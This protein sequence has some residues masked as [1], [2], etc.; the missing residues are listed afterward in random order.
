MQKLVLVFILM[1][2]SASMA[3]EF[4]RS[5]SLEWEPIEGAATYDVEFAPTPKGKPITVLARKSFWNGKLPVGNYNMRVRAKD[6]RKVPGDWSETQ[7]M[8]VG[9][10]NAKLIYPSS[11]YKLASKEA[12]T[13][14]V[15]FKWQPVPG[16]EDYKIEVTSRDGKTKIVEETS[17][18][19]IK[20]KLPVAQEYTWKVLAQRDEVHSD[21][22]TVDE[23]F[24]Q[25]KK[26]DKPEIV[27]P[28]NRFV[29]TIEW[30]H[31]DFA[32]NF[33]YSIQ[34]LNPLTKKWENVGNKSEFKDTSVVFDPAWPGGQ[35]RISVRATSNVRVNS[36]ISQL[37]FPVANGDRSPAAEE[38]G[39]L[40]ES[41]NRT[42][43]WFFT[44][45][46]LV[47]G[48]SYKG[49]DYDSPSPNV[50][51]KDLF[52]GTGRFGVGF[53]DGEKPWGFLGIV[54]YSGFN[55][56]DRTYNFGSIEL[57]AIHRKQVSKDGELR[58]YVG[59]YYKE[60]PALVNLN[61]STQSFDV[62]EIASG[63]PHYG[64]EYWWALSQK[65]GFQV[66]GHVYY[67]VLTFKTPNGER[68]H[69]EMTYQLGLLGS[70]KLGSKTTG[71]MGY[72]YRLD[73]LSYDSKNN[74]NLN[75]ASF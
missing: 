5:V 45:S 35:Y 37:T 39:A 30:K 10:E 58:Q 23:F 31:P 63:G 44:A 15:V 52:G 75:K 22:A 25:G 34:K 72:A 50:D 13:E 28:A 3:S 29:R 36:D 60:L 62:T 53:L 65:L 69:P 56:G 26:L 51:L 41:I 55:I 2:S 33:D 21:A 42:N 57:N 68:I 14:T 8:T 24:I 11:N 54:D 66:N 19:E 32:E 43:G 48:L 7:A 17:K 61:F 9:L 12:E 49:K 6:R 67:S 1:I 16:A 64:A 40:R 46:Y 18:Q 27:P 71:L 70:Y 38:V 4:R 74:G 20:V 47:T 73:S 59:I